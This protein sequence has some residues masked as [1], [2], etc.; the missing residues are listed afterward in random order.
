MDILDWRGGMKDYRVTSYSRPSYESST[1]NVLS[2]NFFH[3]LSANPKGWAVSSI[4]KYLKED[5]MG[6]KMYM[7]LKE[8]HDAALSKHQLYLK[9]K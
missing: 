2:K 4:D 5:A 3:C 6:S 9:N 7:Q 1:F 8:E